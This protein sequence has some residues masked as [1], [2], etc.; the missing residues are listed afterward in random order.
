MADEDPYS[1]PGTDVLRNHFGIRDATELAQRESGLT[2]V[3]IAELERR[4]IS[5]DYDTAHLQAVHRKIFADL[6]PWAGE[7]RTVKIAKGGSVFALPQHVT[8]YLTG[9]LS[10]LANEERLRGLERDDFVT[11]IAH[12]F[13]ELNAV[14]P[15]REGNG[16]T[17]RAFLGHIAS[18]AGYPIDWTGLDADRNI[19][20]SRESHRGDNEPLRKLLDGLIAE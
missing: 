16:R 17:Q 6:Y 4:F 10:D 1:Y 7:L 5:G 8:P 9:V 20:V 15:F 13:A 14:H 3:R 18:E 11:R 19:E 12:Y 2:A